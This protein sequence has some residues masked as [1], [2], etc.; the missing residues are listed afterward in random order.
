MLDPGAEV[1]ADWPGEEEPM[2]CM[3]PNDVLELGD[4]VPIIDEGIP[5]F[6]DDG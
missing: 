5:G 6:M 1:V 3:P 4:C 2:D